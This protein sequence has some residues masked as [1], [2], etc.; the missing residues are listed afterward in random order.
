MKKEKLVKKL[1]AFPS[2]TNKMSNDR[3]IILIGFLYGIL[4]LPFFYVDSA[5]I[6]PNLFASDFERV[7][8]NLIIFSSLILQLIV[9]VIFFKK[10]SQEISLKKI[11]LVLSVLG[12]FSLF[13][14]PVGSNDLYSYIFQS[15]VLSEFGQNPYIHSYGEFSDDVLFGELSNKWDSKT[16]P[17]GPVFIYFA[18]VVSKFAG[19]NII[20]LLGC[21]KSIFICFHILGLIILSKLSKNRKVQYLYAFNPLIVFETYINGHN[22]ILISTLL[23]L[24]FL[25]LQTNKDE[26]RKFYIVLLNSV[27]AFLIKA[28]SLIFIGAFGLQ[29]IL[30]AWKNNKIVQFVFGAIFIIFIP[31]VFLYIPFWEGSN[32][33][34]RVM[35]QAGQFNFLISS[36][37]VF[38][39]YIFLENFSIENSQLLAINFSRGI[40]IIG[41][42]I[43]FYLHAKKQFQLK[44]KSQY[45]PT[46]TLLIVT[47]AAFLAT[48]Y[49]WFLPWYLLSLLVLM[50]IKFSQND[51]KII[52]IIVFAIT[53]YGICFYLVL[54]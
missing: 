42:L 14:V 44:E 17:Y 5:Q 15:R 13:F 35:T 23:L 10:I 26:T 7:K 53:L 8:D 47:L 12:I 18:S 32:T 25:A 45:K 48:F 3:I 54:D 2:S 21:F 43:Y 52:K 11:I 9:Y 37:L 51:Q 31:V 41:I 4:F 20:V 33:I 19:N 36:P 40:F 46:T 50:I 27:I 6:E 16:S 1:S 30:S 34:N 49:S 29:G 38:A 28:S 39:S 24:S 22:E